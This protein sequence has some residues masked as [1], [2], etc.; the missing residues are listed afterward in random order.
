MNRLKHSQ[1]CQI[2]INALIAADQIKG[3]SVLATLDTMNHLTRTLPP[4]EFQLFDIKQ[5]GRDQFEVKMK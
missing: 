3:L 4:K 2:L 5:V 1:S